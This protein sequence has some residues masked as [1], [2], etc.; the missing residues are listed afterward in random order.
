MTENSA[1]SLI[2]IAFF[3][4]SIGGLLWV[5]WKIVKAQKQARQRESKVKAELEKTCN[6]KP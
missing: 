1:D 3:V 4:V 5:R 6:D 2:I